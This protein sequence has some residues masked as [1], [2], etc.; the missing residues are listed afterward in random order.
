MLDL[1]LSSG[2]LYLLHQKPH[3]LLP[4]LEAVALLLSILFQAL[5][6]GVDGAFFRLVWVE[7]RA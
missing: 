2:H 3:Q 5:N 7:T 6:L 4:L 1:N